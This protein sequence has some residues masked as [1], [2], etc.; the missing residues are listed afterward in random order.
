MN[1]KVSN[2]NKDCDEENTDYYAE[3]NKP[4]DNSEYNGITPDILFPFH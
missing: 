2:R 4:T 3:D 1:S